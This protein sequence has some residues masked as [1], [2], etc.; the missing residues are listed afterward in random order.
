MNHTGRP[1][2]PFTAELFAAIPLM[3]T[4][5]FSV[6][7]STCEPNE[8]EKKRLENVDNTNITQ[9][10][11]AN[12][13]LRESKYIFP[14]VGSDFEPDPRLEAIDAKMEALYKTETIMMELTLNEP[15][16]YDRPHFDDDGA[17]YCSECN[18]EKDIASY[19]LRN[20]YDKLCFDC[21]ALP[22]MDDY[23]EH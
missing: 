6:T 20:D 2:P 1:Q 4:D 8:L 17:E 11:G 14:L 10:S 12:I 16:D 23:N 21:W 22:C 19:G 9:Y 15:E 5:N 13:G 7:R 18:Q 3:H